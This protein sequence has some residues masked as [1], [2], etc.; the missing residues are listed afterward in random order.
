MIDVILLFVMRSFH[1]LTVVMMTY[2]S[3][4][5]H[6]LSRCPSHVIIFFVVCSYFV[7]F[8]VTFVILVF[9]ILIFCAI[10][11][12][13]ISFLRSLTRVAGIFRLKYTLTGFYSEYFRLSK[14]Y[15]LLKNPLDA[16]FFLVKKR[17]ECKKL[18]QIDSVKHHCIVIE[19]DEVFLVT[20]VCNYDEHD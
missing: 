10:N 20:S 6:H 16:I 13:S 18:I 5:F 3:P 8:S 15:H 11:V 19:M 12:P 7:S 17:A 2:V 14:Y 4:T 1:M 9:I